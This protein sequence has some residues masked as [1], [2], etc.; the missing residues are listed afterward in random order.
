[1]K[2][3]YIA[4]LAIFLLP[5]AN[6]VIEKPSWSIGSYWEYNGNIRIYAD[7]HANYPVDNT[8]YETSMTVDYQMALNLFTKVDGVTIEEKDG[9]VLPCYIMKLNVDGDGNGKA[10]IVTPW[11]NPLTGKI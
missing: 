11:Q 6:A 2:L 5:F 3:R 10:T 7:Q 8:T 9:E 4:M 1:M